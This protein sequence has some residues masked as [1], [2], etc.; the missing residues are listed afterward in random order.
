MYTNEDR[1]E[2]DLGNNTRWFEYD[3][4]LSRILENYVTLPLFFVSLIGNSLI[5]IVFSRWCYRNNLTAMLYRIIAVADALV[6]VIQDGM[7]TLPFVVL[8]RSIYTQNSITC[9]FAVF[10]SSWFRTFSV[11]IIAVLATEKL[12][13]VCWPHH[14]KRVNTKQKYGWMVFILLIVSCVLYLPLTVTVVHT[15]TVLNGQTIGICEI[16]GRSQRVKGYRAIFLWM[17]VLVSS[18]LPFLFVAITNTAT[19]YCLHKT[20]KSPTTVRVIKGSSSN[21]DGIGRMR[22]NITILLLISTTTVV[23]TQPDPLYLLLMTYITDTEPDAFHRL[24]T[25]SYGLPSFDSVNRSVNITLFC[26]FSRKFRLNL[27]GLLLC[28]RNNRDGG[29]GREITPE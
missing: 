14:V 8:G 27:K 26:T 3:S 15:T 29:I 7:H 20:R 10:A 2:L 9:K 22:S 16:S 11:W 1:Y 18:V 19:V 13:C 28:N 12:I 21:V 4:A 23:F 17:N 6:I 24:I 5:V 25:F